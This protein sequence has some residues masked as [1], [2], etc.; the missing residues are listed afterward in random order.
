MWG[1]DSCTLLQH[2]SSGVQGPSCWCAATTTDAFPPILAWHLWLVLFCQY[3]VA[4]SLPPARGS[5]YVKHWKVPP[6]LFPVKHLRAVWPKNC[7]SRKVPGM[8]QVF[9]IY[10]VPV[11]L[12]HLDGAKKQLG[13]P[14]ITVLRILD[15]LGIPE[16]LPSLLEMLLKSIL[17]TTISEFAKM[18]QGGSGYFSY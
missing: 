16:I 1:G 15:K 10:D 9:V 8:A 18:S 14:E 7:W 3:R 12:F 4:Q 2:L 11:P 17:Q 13:V 5:C 6:F